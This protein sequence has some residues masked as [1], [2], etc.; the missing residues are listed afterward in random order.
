MTEGTNPDSVR[1][2]RCS[3][4]IEARNNELRVAVWTWYRQTETPC[5]FPSYGSKTAASRLSRRLLRPLR[6]DLTIERVN[7]SRCRQAAVR[8]IVVAIAY[9]RSSEWPH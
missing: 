7:P 9:V 1:P 5:D 8:R 2:D 4:C 6:C 3:D